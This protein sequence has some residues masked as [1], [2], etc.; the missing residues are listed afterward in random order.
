MI[1]LIR[2]TIFCF[3]ILFQFLPVA[4]ADRAGDEFLAGYVA[5]ILERDLRWERGSYSLKV[6]NGVA[7]ITL[8]EDDPVRQETAGNQLRD[9]D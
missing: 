5:S 7:T 1:L 6:V 2:F 4:A 8:F 9:I 3:M